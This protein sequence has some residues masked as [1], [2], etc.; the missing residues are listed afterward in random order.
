V[1]NTIDSQICH[2]LLIFFKYTKV[3]SYLDPQ[4]TDIKIIEAI[5]YNYPLSVQKAMLNIQ[6]KT[7]GEAFKKNRNHGHT[8]TIE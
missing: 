8:G 5:R 1:T 6:L 3:A 2:Y 4:R 7:I